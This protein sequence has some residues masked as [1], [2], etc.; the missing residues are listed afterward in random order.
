MLGHGVTVCR[1]AGAD[2]V[3]SADG[4]LTRD[5]F[6]GNDAVHGRGGEVPVYLVSDDNFD[7][8]QPQGGGVTR[9]R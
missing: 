1:T 8:L 7:A 4:A 3:A 5:N 6:E 2:P 9:N